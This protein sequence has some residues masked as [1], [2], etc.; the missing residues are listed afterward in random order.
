MT[1]GELWHSKARNY[2][3]ADMPTYGTC[4]GLGFQFTLLIVVHSSQQ[5]R[6]RNHMGHKK[7]TY[8]GWI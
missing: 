6:F 8:E 7:L 4:K 1:L 5:R 2:L 3:Q